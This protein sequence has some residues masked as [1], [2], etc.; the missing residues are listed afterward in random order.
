MTTPCMG[1]LPFLVSLPTLWWY[2][3]GCLPHQPL[4]STSCRRAWSCP[5]SCSHHPGNLTSLP[6][7]L[8]PRM[9]SLARPLRPLAE[10]GSQAPCRSVHKDLGCG[11]VCGHKARCGWRRWKTP[12]SIVPWAR[13]ILSVFAVGT[14]CRRGMVPVGV[15]TGTTWAGHHRHEGCYIHSQEQGSQSTEVAPEPYTVVFRRT[16]E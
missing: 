4:V 5:S 2:S 11:T 1:F 8:G 6:I 3:Q 7:S 12:S 9:L 15:T 16:G 13:G 10:G 14:G